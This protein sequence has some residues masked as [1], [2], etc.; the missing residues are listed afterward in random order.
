MTVSSEGFAAS[1]RLW[2][3]CTS[4]C[5]DRRWK[6][7]IFY[8]YVLLLRALKELES[9]CPQA[10]VSGKSCDGYC[11]SNQGS[12]GRDGE[13]DNARIFIC[14]HIFSLTL[15]GENL[16]EAWDFSSCHQ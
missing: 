3:P 13:L 1:A 2:N 16:Q 14:V 9:S 4:S 12:R 7:G 6:T 8:G 5:T 15:V 11:L 10:K